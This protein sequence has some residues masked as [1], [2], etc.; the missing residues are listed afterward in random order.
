[1]DIIKKCNVKISGSGSQA[2]VFAH[3][4]G[5]DQ[6]MWRKV[7]P[8]FE[9]D[10][11]VVLFDYVGAGMSDLDAYDPELYSSLAGYAKDVVDL[12]EALDLHDAILVGH[13]VSSMICLLAARDIP[14]R[15]SKLV[16]ICP[17]ARYLN[18]APDYV[19]G[20][21]RADIEGLLDM[22]SRNQPGWASYLAGVV[23]KNP[24]QPALAQELEAS[25]CA[26]DPPIAKRFAEATFLADNRL[27]LVDFD[28][29]CLLLQCQEDSVAPLVV[30]EYLHQHLQNSVLQQMKA[31]GHCPHMSHPEETIAL[32]KNYLSS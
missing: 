29:P 16:M 22:I 28:K 20:F 3:G 27:D 14:D 21:E 32:M 19:G 9:K 11:N 15:I 1:M 2:I 6:E 17:S 25:F 31:T 30:G 7:S 5:C 24:D 23:A 4:Y 10:F 26:M 13:S 12:C 8:A 18:D